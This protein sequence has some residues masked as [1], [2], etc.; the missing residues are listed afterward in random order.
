MIATVRVTEPGSGRQTPT[1]TP[2]GGMYPAY[3]S[4]QAQHFPSLNL[5]FPAAPSAAGPVWCHIYSP[6]SM[7][8][9]TLRL[10]NEI[11]KGKQSWGWG[12]VGGIILAANEQLYNF[13]QKQSWG[14]LSL[15][16][17]PL[18]TVTIKGALKEEGWWRRWG[19][20]AYCQEGP[21]WSGRVLERKVSPPFI[22]HFLLPSWLH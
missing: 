2:Q 15:T 9:W 3:Q 5:T 17:S 4:V 12:C 16:V 18:N 14:L 19:G 8:C 11:P 6:C 10:L 7:R 21:L 22:C 13:Y 20:G 1:H